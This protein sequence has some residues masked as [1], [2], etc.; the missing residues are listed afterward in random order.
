MNIFR[1]NDNVKTAKEYVDSKR[2]FNLFY[3]LNNNPQKNKITCIKNNKI[4]RIVNHENLIHLTKGYYDY[5]QNNKCVSKDT[6]LITTYDVEQ[7][8]NKCKINISNNADISNNYTGHVLTSNNTQLLDTT[9]TLRKHYAEETVIVPTT[10]NDG[11]N[12]EYK[13]TTKEVKC[14]K[15]HTNGFKGM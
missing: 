10:T 9:T 13:K 5:Y 6:N 7:F 2:N 12:F 3:D 14:F 11:N 4:S 1:N 8:D 15:L